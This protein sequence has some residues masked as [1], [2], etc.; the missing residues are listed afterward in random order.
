M[1]DGLKV[2]SLMASW[3]RCV[4]GVQYALEKLVMLLDVV[5]I[6][7]HST[8]HLA[9]E[10][11]ICSLHKIALEAPVKPSAVSLQPLALMR[12]LEFAKLLE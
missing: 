1:Q 8:P 4:Y 5:R 9:L 2:E 12:L 11:S 7:L 10:A 6:A 3:K